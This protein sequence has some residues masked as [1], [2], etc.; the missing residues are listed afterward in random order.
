MDV[1]HQRQLSQI[2]LGPRFT[3]S[4]SIASYLLLD[5]RVIHHVVA[6]YNCTQREHLRRCSTV[7]HIVAE[8]DVDE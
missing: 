7:A 4:V 6:W 3:L 2:L 5:A 8:L 1:A